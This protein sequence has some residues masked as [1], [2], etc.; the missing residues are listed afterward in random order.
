[1]P[2]GQQFFLNMEGIEQF[3]EL[4]LGRICDTSEIDG[5]L[6]FFPRGNA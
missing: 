5:V 1:M 4:G 3:V 2:D 6:H